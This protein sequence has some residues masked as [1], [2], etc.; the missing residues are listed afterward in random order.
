MFC[1]CEFIKNNIGTV[2]FCDTVYRLLMVITVRVCVQS[3]DKETRCTP[4]LHRGRS[5]TIFH[6]RGLRVAA[7]PRLFDGSCVP[8]VVWFH[9]VRALQSSRSR[10]YADALLALAD[11]LRLSRFSRWTGELNR[12]SNAVFLQ[13]RRQNK[14]RGLFSFVHGLCPIHTHLA[15][16]VNWP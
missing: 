16:S 8:S 13:L 5:R 7:W 4:V 14:L 1:W 15:V 6:W 10:C 3:S 2:L 9:S 11:L 12:R